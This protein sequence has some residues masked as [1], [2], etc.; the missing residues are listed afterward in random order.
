MLIRIT[1]LLSTNSAWG[2]V[3]I[4]GTRGEF[5]SRTAAPIDLEAQ[6]SSQPLVRQ[7]LNSIKFPV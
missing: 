2:E 6:L 4:S 3:E 5:K 1:I 7:N